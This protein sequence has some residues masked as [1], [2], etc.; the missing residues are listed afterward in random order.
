LDDKTTLDQDV[1]SGEARREA[2]LVLY[3]ESGVRAVP[4]VDG[5]PVVIGRAA[6]AEVIVDHLSLSRQHA[7]VT[8]KGGVVTVED[9]G[10]T[11]GTHFR[12]ER[13][14]GEARIAPGEP[15]QLGAIS[16]SISVTAGDARLRGVIGHERFLAKLDDEILRARSFRRPLAVAMIR[17]I[18]REGGEATRW[19]GRV[20]AGLRPVDA[21]TLYAPSAVLVLLPEADRET[22]A[23]ALSTIVTARVLGEPPLVAGISVFPEAS[24]VD[25]LVDDARKAARRAVPS[26]PVVSSGDAEGGSPRS[27]VVSSASMRELY[28]L[29]RKVAAASVPVL[30]MGETG[31]GKEV[32]AR[33]IHAESPRRALPMR[34]INCGAMPETL[35]PSVLFGHEKGAFTGAE[36]RAPGLFEQA[37][38]GTV[39]LD[40][41]GELSPQAQAALL[42]VLETKRLLRVGGAEEV[43]VDVRVVAAT[44]RDLERMVQAGAFRQDLFYRLNTMVLRVPPLRERAEEIDAL[45]DLFL[46]EARVASGASARGLDPEARALLRRYRW[47]GNVRELRNVIE[48]AVLVAPG[49]LVT[50]ADLDERIAA[51]SSFDDVTAPGAAMAAAGSAPAGDFKDRVQRYETDLILDALKRTN[52]NQTQ[53]AKLLG[54]PLRTLVHKLKAYGIRKQYGEEGE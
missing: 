15:F 40:E 48:R 3:E 5:V 51:P 2:S 4:L 46:E 45:A 31:T 33:A 38:G 36:H 1:T 42:R 32:I 11:N 22:A 35:L 43:E 19:V 9:L 13:L 39:F 17:S 8:W 20:R 24:S 37:S 41:V 23:R 53:A 54:M 34:S 52:G 18:A 7:R 26:A 12:G 47:P 30:V 49:D 50:A 16:A 29:V 27:V 6:P 25:A 14:R 21:L 28:A 44:H 10:S